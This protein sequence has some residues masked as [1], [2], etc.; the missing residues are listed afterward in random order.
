MA[1]E[2]TPNYNLDLYTSTDKPNL[3]DQY[4]AA[5]GKIDTQLKANADGVTNVSAS[6]VAATAAANEA[7][8]LAENAA[9]KNHAS[10]TSQYGAAT[11]LSYGHVVLAPVEQTA[12]EENGKATSPKAVYDFVNGGYAPINHAAGSTQYGGA[13]ANSYGHVRLT[14]SA[15]SVS[16][17]SQAIG[18]SPLCV[19]NKIEKVKDYTI[20]FAQDVDISEIHPGKVCSVKI[21]GNKATGIVMVGVSFPSFINSTITTAVD[22][23][24]C[25][26]PV[27]SDFSGIVTATRQI[28]GTGLY[29]SARAGT[30][31]GT[32]NIWLHAQGTTMSAPGGMGGSLVYFAGTSID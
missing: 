18:A 30:T 9:P 6:V 23:L 22:K 2:Y 13:T 32:V 27:S 26:I 5:M 1:T 12:I 16:S 25:T 7:K 21:I 29:L 28:V 8:E 14:D 11:A 31:P 4:N 17:A 24:L 3:R 20:L 15:S 10:Q 19:D